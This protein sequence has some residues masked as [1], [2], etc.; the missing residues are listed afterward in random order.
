[1]M[2]E[3]EGSFKHAR[4]A[5]IEGKPYPVK[6]F[7]TYKTNPMATGA[8]RRKTIEM[9]NKLDFMIIGG[10][11]HERYGLDGRSGPSSPTLSGAAGPGFPASRGLRR[12]LFRYPRSGGPCALS[13]PNR[14]SGSSRNWPNVWTSAN[15]LISPWRNTARSSSKTLPEA[16][17]GPEKRWRLLHP[18]QA[19][20]AL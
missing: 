5:V 15:F 17:S 19:L 13:N 14:F 16:A 7:F 18:G 12:R 10:H 8:N 20:R 2:F 4:D 9:I 6:G 1:M 11:C 3:E